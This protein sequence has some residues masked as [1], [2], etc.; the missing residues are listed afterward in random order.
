MKMRLPCTRTTLARV[1]CVLSCTTVLIGMIALFS[2]HWLESDR[3]HAGLIS[4]CYG[5]TCVSVTDNISPSFKTSYGVGVTM[6]MYLPLV[7][8]FVTAV[9]QGITVV[10][11]PSTRRDVSG[12]VLAWLSGYHSLLLTILMIA[13]ASMIP[14]PQ[15][16]DS[17]AMSSQFG[18]PSTTT[19]HSSYIGDGY[20]RSEHE[21]MEW[22]VSEHSESSY[23]LSWNIGW[24][25]YFGLLA[26]M[27]ALASAVSTS[28]YFGKPDNE[29]SEDTIPLQ[30]N[31]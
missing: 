9:L 8:I 28:L 16:T 4:G 7:L 23:D 31:V 5:D 19:A 30:S 3:M 25:A 27:F 15:G 12:L 17:R 13:A 14:S 10:K 22:V 11:G 21:H 18:Y 26:A 6:L 2:N 24:S 1:S 20:L 29:G